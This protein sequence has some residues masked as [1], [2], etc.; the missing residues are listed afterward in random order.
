MLLLL[1][2]IK[3]YYLALIR[4]RAK[5]GKLFGSKNGRKGS[6]FHGF[7]FN[8]AELKPHNWCTKGFYLCDWF[9]IPVLAFWIII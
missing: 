4:I 8:S 2:I 6:F 3:D 1:R 5:L 7:N 9:E